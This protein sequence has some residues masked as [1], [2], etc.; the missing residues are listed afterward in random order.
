[1]IILEFLW[2]QFV[3]DRQGIQ[4]SNQNFGIGP[5]LM[6]IFS[7]ETIFSSSYLPLFSISE[8]RRN[9]IQSQTYQERILI[10]TEFF[11]NLLKNKLNLKFKLILSIIILK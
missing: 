10:M 3:C 1:M 11:Q 5:R 9:S 8:I 6:E 4:N 7:V 2:L